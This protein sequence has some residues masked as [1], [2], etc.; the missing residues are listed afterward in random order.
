MSDEPSDKNSPIIG[1]KMSDGLSDTTSESTD[2]SS[3]TESPPTPIEPTEPTPEPV[4][5]KAAQERGGEGGEKS[6]K[7]KPEKTPDYLK[8]PHLYAQEPVSDELF[9]TLPLTQR[10]TAMMSAI[11]WHVERSAESVEDVYRIVTAK[12][13]GMERAYLHHLRQ[14]KGATP[15][16][17]TEFIRQ[18]RKDPYGAKAKDPGLIASRFRDTLLPPETPGESTTPAAPRKKLVP[19]AGH[20]P[21]KGT[22]YYDDP[23][24]R[25][26]TIRCDCWHEVTIGEVAS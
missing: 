25:S 4:E 1:Q 23:K 18:Y 10:T 3:I 17:L 6:V 21:C 20:E 8:N 2:N 24:D 14:V 12:K 9:T 15:K 5:S 26:T 7:V 13:S 11:C 22:G 19:L 16:K